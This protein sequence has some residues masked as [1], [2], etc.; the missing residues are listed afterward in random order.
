MER[1]KIGQ[2]SSTQG[3][4]TGA[5]HLP[6]GYYFPSEFSR[7]SADQ[8]AVLDSLFCKQKDTYLCFSISHG[9]GRDASLNCTMGELGINTLQKLIPPSQSVS[10]SQR[11][12]PSSLFFSLS[13]WRQNR[14]QGIQLCPK[15]EGQQQSENKLTVKVRIG[16]QH[17]VSLLETNREQTL[18]S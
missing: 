1:C 11:L 9:G 10:S 14:F 7:A 18:G 2:P 6:L 5:N 16:G 3:H 13:W 12:P 4:D 15:C 8:G 17:T